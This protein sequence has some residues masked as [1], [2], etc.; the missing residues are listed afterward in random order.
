[1]NNETYNGWTNYE[2]WRVNLELIDSDYYE[3]LINEQFEDD[4]NKDAIAGGLADM[5][6]EDIES[7]ICETSEDDSIAQSYA[8]A[9][10]S[11][12]NWYE[13]AEHITNDMEA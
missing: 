9:F 2:T 11:G 8:L 7:Y 12:V 10:V 3:N 4:D 1:M 5:L 13:I 6:K